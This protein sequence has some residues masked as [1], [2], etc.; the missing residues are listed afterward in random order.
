MY[1]QCCVLVYV[2]VSAPFNQILLK[3]VHHYCV[4]NNLILFAVEQLFH[5]MDI[6]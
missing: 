6:L 2:C 5:C 3:F 1:M 4:F